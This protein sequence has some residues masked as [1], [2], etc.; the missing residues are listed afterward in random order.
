[1]KAAA[2]LALA[3]CAC[4]TP[5]PAPADFALVPDV[6]LATPDLVIEADDG[7]FRIVSGARMPSPFWTWD[8]PAAPNL[9]NVA[10]ARKLGARPVVVTRAGVRVQGVLAL[11]P[12]APGV[13]PAFRHVYRII[14]PDERMATAAAGGASIAWQPSGF[15]KTYA[16]GAQDV[17]TWILWL[18]PEPL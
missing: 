9:D 5:G 6:E 14:V 18:A 1:M 3:L 13:F 12:T 17:P 8:C 15:S 4:A 10:L 2:F 16:D 7:S 11:C